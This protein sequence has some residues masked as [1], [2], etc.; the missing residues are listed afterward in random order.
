[1]EGEEEEEGSDMFGFLEMVGVEGEEGRKGVSSDAR[2]RRIRGEEE[3]ASH[4]PSP[5]SP[6][7]NLKR[8][9]FSSEDTNPLSA[10]SGPA[11][12]FFPMR[13]S[14]RGRLFPPVVSSTFLP[15]SFLRFSL[16]SSLS[17]DPSFIA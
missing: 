10:F 1:M 3:Q 2:S 5:H 7:F 15:S 16:C 6:S 13:S 14:G 8:H 11:I 12:H 4:E 17:S 9:I